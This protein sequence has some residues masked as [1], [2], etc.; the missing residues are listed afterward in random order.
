MGFFD[1]IADYFNASTQNMILCIVI[2]VIAVALIVLIIAAIVLGAKR[3]KQKRAESAPAEETE[4]TSPE[5]QPELSAQDAGQPSRAP[6]QDA[7]E[8]AVSLGDEGTEKEP[9]TKDA[10]GPQPAAEAQA[11]EAAPEDT[12][13]EQ[14]AAPAAPEKETKNA[15]PPV[16]QEARPAEA[17][18]ETASAAAKTE[19]KPSAAKAAAK[20]AEKKAEAA[21]PAEKKAEETKPAEKPAES[22]PAVKGA[23]TKPAPAKTEKKEEEEEKKPVY[24]GKWVIR[25]NEETGA[26]YFDLL[27]S[28]GEKLLSSIDYTS[29]SGARN[30]IQTHKTNIAK[31]NF[32][33]ATS[34]NKQYFFKLMNGS[35]QLL[36]TGE[37]Y[38]VR[39]RCESAIESVKRFA[40]T[41]VIVVDKGDKE[42]EA[43]KEEK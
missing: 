39:A 14:N 33:I 4:Q 22:K 37:T 34:K 19:T 42:K 16:K 40:E 24:A 29:L 15:E 3:S 38:K 8:S 6:A 18:R 27:A 13:A 17:K 12:A 11:T 41:A 32:S 1:K 9:H 30:G 36:C 21:K 5:K 7:A 43:E 23:E 28:N 25:K 2:A 31:G 10:D 35:K 26:Y 20:P